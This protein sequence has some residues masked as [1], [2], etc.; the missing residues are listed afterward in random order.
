MADD[1]TIDQ[2]KDRAKGLVERATGAVK[3]VA[4]GIG[5]FFK[6]LFKRS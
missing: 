4:G 5:D 1:G 2:A 3:G 6:G